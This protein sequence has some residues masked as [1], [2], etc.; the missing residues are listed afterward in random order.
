M[1]MGVDVIMLTGDN[2]A[3]AQAVAAEAGIQ[4]VIA[5][6]LPQDK[7]KVVSDLRNK[8]KTVAMVGDGI[9]DAP[10]LAAADVGM[11]IGAG[12]DVAIESADIVLMRSDLRDVPAA[13]RLSKAVL[14]NIRENLFWAFFYNVIGIPIAAGLLFLPFGFRLSPMLGALAMSLSSVCVVTNAL[15]LKW[16][17]ARK[18]TANEVLISEVHSLNNLTQIKEKKR[19]KQVKIDGMMCMHCVGSVKKALSEIG[20]EAEVSLEEKTARI[21]QEADS[22]AVRKAIEGAGYTVISID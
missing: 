12:T 11:A 19:M 7:E 6:V 4:N 5:Q 10:A 14:R 18:E 3:T 20:I 15:R 21:P 2:Q 8:G 9:N 17:K 13:V 16:F 22:E 1:S